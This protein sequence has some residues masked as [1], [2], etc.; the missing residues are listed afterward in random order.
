[1]ALRLTTTPIQAHTKGEVKRLR[2]DGYVP[3]SIQHRGQ[4]PLHLQTESKPLDEF[5]RQHGESALLE[6]VLPNKKRQT[7]IVKQVQR[8]PLSH[9]LLQV[10]FQSVSRD[11]PIKVHIP[12]LFHG[13]PE[14]VRQHTGV[15]LHQLEQVEVRCLPQNLPDHLTV[16]ISHLSIGESIHASDLP[17]SDKHEILTAPDTVLASLT[18]VAV[19]T[20]EAE[21]TVAETG[22]VQATSPAEETQQES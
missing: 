6:M 11:E 16:D 3:I 2:R 12:I 10:T 13:E 21:E 1:M 17:Q 22:E 8:D 4:E 9:R 7:T 18:S 5:I 14:A 19:A 15:V 20:T